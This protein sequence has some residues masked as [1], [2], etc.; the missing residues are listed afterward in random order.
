MLFLVPSNKEKRRV[1]DYLDEN[2]DR[3]FPKLREG[4]IYV[5]GSAAL[6]KGVR[7]VIED[8]IGGD[9]TQILGRRYIEEVF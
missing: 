1:Q 8:I 9:I 7:P 4:F 3:L 2:K 6:I 5:C